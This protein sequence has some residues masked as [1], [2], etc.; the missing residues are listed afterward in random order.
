MILF[1]TIVA[2][3]IVYK[4]SGIN[5]QDLL[6]SST[7]EP[8]VQKELSQLVNEYYRQYVNTMSAVKSEEEMIG[9]SIRFLIDSSYY[10]LVDKGAFTSGTFLEYCDEHIVNKGRFYQH[11][12]NSIMTLNDCVLSDTLTDPEKVVKTFNIYSKAGIQQGLQSTIVPEVVNS[13][14]QRIIQNVTAIILITTVAVALL[15]LTEGGIQ[16]V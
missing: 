2:C 14:S 12:K 16:E 9:K 8:N 10:N 3:I 1:G 5:I 15:V 11:F 7:T 6:F 13:N 4:F